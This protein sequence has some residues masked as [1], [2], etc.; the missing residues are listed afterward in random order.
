MIMPMVIILTGMIVYL[1][2]YLYDRCI[3]SQDVY[4]LAFHG[5]LC[6]GE[7]TED[8]KQTIRKESDWRFGKKYISTAN[9]A[10]NAGADRSMVTVEAKGKMATVGWGF[11]AKWEAQRICPT[12]CVR[13]VRLVKRIKSGIEN[14]FSREKK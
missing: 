10:W 14:K 3:V 5:S 9:F 8:I 11:E 6:C 4:I 1:T 7:E 12:N 13:N 2:F